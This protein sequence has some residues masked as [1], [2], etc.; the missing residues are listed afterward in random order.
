MFQ[1][2][3]LSTV[4]FAILLGGITLSS[5]S[6]VRADDKNR[7]ADDKNKKANDKNKKEATLTADQVAESVVFIYSNRLGRGF[8]EQIRRNGVERGR[9]T[10]I[11]TDGRTEEA[12]YERRFVRG[13]NSVKDKIRLDQK[14]SSAEYSL[15]YGDGRTFG[16]VNG[17]QFEPRQEAATDF[18]AQQWHGLDALLRYKENGS[19]LKLVG[20]DTQQGV[21]FYVLE[22]TDKEKRN[23]RYYIS[24]KTLRVMRL[25][26][27]AA[28]EGSATPVKYM[29]KF[30]DYRVAQGTLIPYRSVL[31]EDGKQTQESKVLSVT[32]G[33]KMDDTYFQGPDAQANAS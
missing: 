27:E 23:T 11:G 2:T 18:L 5:H 3:I 26:Y 8:L 6:T 9:V 13:E 24:T 30:Y 7:K 10:R 14:L 15:V 28:A 25:D 16:I 31:Y 12:T 4:A 32:Y 19:T 1:R 20:K 33:I 29:R 21:D 22:V 17:S